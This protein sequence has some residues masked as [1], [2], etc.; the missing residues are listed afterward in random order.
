MRIRPSLIAAVA[1]AALL[2]GPVGAAAQFE[3]LYSEYRQSGGRIDA[4]AHSTE[5]LT[6]ALGEIPA[7]IQAYDPEFADAL[8]RALDRRIAGCGGEAGN[9]QGPEDGR[10]T[11]VAGDGS[12]GPT[13]PRQVRLGDLDVD[14][15]GFPLAL[16]AAMVAA[17]ALLGASAAIA[18]ARRH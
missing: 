16:V 18:V 17:A 12:P 10:G 15:P 3:R 2:A 4:C 1:I 8:N 14:E 7:D 5:E 6:G 11:V 13:T 9:E